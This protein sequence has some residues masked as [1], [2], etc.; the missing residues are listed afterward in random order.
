M[1]AEVRTSD[2]ALTLFPIVHYH[3]KRVEGGQLVKVSGK[4]MVV[5]GCLVVLNT[6]SQRRT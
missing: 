4:P 6:T 5:G 3:K 2:S 1:V